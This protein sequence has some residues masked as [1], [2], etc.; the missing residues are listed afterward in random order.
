MKQKR[1]MAIFEII[2]GLTIISLSLISLIT[3]YR[4]HLKE[5]SASIEEIKSS[6]LAEE[7][8]EVVRLLRDSSWTENI[9]SLNDGTDYYIYWNGVVWTSTTTPQYVDELIRSFKLS[10]V[11]DN[12]NIK[13]VDVVV[14]GKMTSTYIT[15]L[16]EN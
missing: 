15:N 1:G 9:V 16:F 7:T 3:N 4:A 6:Y 14:N 2:I 5:S 12:E 11:D 10:S 13:K 8:L